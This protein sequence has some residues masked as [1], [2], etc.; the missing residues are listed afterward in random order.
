MSVL[1]SVLYC[2]QVFQKSY[3][4]RCWVKLTTYSGV[5][6]GSITQVSC[7]RLCKYTSVHLLTPFISFTVQHFSIFINLISFT[8]VFSP[9][10]YFCFL[11]IPHPT[12]DLVQLSSFPLLCF[13]LSVSSQ[14]TLWSPKICTSLFISLFNFELVPRRATI[15]KSVT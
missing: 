4:T 7:L 14:S 3:W 12:Y 6:S 1:P 10:V 13:C 9:H 8:S 5:V 15:S 2:A 11:S